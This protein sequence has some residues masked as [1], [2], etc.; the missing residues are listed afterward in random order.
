L[1]RNIETFKMKG[2][3][4]KQIRRIMHELGFNSKNGTSITAAEQRARVSCVPNTGEILSQ[5]M[6][7]N[8]GK[9]YA[10]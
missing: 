1:A 10:H 4:V 5:I 6:I 8:Y 3:Y 9:K 7:K 2:I